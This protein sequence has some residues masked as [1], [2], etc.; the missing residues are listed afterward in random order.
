MAEETKLKLINK[1]TAAKVLVLG[2]GSLFNI[3]D[4]TLSIKEKGDTFS[5]SLFNPIDVR[6]RRKLTL[7]GI[8]LEK[9]KS[10]VLQFDSRE[11][12]IATTPVK[13]RLIARPESAHRLRV[14][15]AEQAGAKK[16]ILLDP[17]NYYSRK[18]FGCSGV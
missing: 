5:G 8:S 7:E 12:S 17:E 10:Y 2:I 16:V 1:M 14:A 11:I 9:P 6:F 18:K 4:Q 13:T 15:V 3:Q